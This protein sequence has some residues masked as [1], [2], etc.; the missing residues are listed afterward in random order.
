VTE[1]QQ[2][3]YVIA[4]LRRATTRWSG[5]IARTF[6]YGLEDS[7][8]EPN[9]LHR[10]FGLRRPDGTPKPAWAALSAFLDSP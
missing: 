5:T 7:P 10:G 4:A 8:T 6:V 3:A 9:S 1:S 2:A